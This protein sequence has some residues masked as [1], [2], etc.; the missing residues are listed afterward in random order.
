MLDRIPRGFWQC[1]KLK[2]FAVNDK[3]NLAP[4]IWGLCSDSIS[5]SV[6]SVSN[7]HISLSL[8]INSDIIFVYG[9]Y[10][11]TSYL[12]RR[13]LWSNLAFLQQNNIGPWCFLGDFIA[14]LG[15]HE[16]RGGNPPMAVSCNEL[17][18]WSDVCNLTHIEIRG[19]AYTWAN[20]RVLLSIL[21]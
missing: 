1:L 6:L 20:G 11:S 19:A 7:Q 15:S 12:N 17:K 10:A 8:L 9:I 14:I 5:P 4:N 21:N 2:V 18:A 3:M 13:A 16:K